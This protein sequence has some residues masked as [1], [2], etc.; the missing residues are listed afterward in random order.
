M[1]PVFLSSKLDRV[2]ADIAGSNAGR[3]PWSRDGVGANGETTAPRSRFRGGIVVVI[4]ALMGAFFTERAWSAEFVLKRHES[5]VL[6]V[7]RTDLIH[8]PP[9]GSVLFTGSSSI[10]KWVRLAEDFPGVPVLNR[11]FGG[12][13]WRELNHY[14]PRLV[15]KYQPRAVVVYEGDNDLAMGRSVADCLADFEEFIRLMRQHLPDVPVAILTVKPS[16]SRRALGPAQDQLNTALRNRLQD[17]SSWTVL[18]VGNVLLDAQG[19]LRP[20]L[21]EAD[22]L[23]LRP[24]GYAL[25][26]P[27]LRP[28]VEKF[29]GP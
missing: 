6:K 23:H 9:P 7:E 4:L 14:F 24:S 29:G 8:P 20:E 19:K 25:W 26:V 27:V 5:E 21:Y 3:G 16:P 10:V 28:W 17:Q 2:R 11:G 18:E 22:Q 1:H 13:T 15:A 12:S